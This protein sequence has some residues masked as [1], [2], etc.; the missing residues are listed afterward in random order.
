MIDYTFFK[1]E[2]II[3]KRLMPGSSI[4]INQIDLDPNFFVWAT[5]QDLRKFNGNSWEYYD[6]TNSS[7]P[8]G[9][10][11][12]LDTRC[13]SID[14]KGILWGGIA[15]ASNGIN[16]TNS[17]DVDFYN[18][19]SSGFN[20]V[21]YSTG[22]QSDGKIIMG[23]GFTLFNGF[24][25]N[26]LLRLNPDG[27]ED[28]SFYSNLGTGFNGLILFDSIKIQSDGKILVGGTFNIFNGNTRNGL[29]RLNSDGTEDTSFYTNLG[30]GF[31]GFIYSI[32]LQADGKILVGG[33]FNSFNGN[34]RN[35]IVRL[36]PD[37][38]EDTSFYT[39]V[40]STGTGNAFN[41]VVYFIREQIDGRILV[42][43]NYLSFNGGTRRRLVRLNPSGL[44]DSS[45]YTNLSPLGS[46]FNAAVYGIAIQN[47]GKIIITG[48][49]NVLDSSLRDKIVRLNSNGSEDTQFYTNVTSTGDGSGFQNGG[50]SR[51]SIQTDGKIIV[52]GSFTDFNDNGGFN[53]NR[54]LRLNPD[55]TEDSSFYTPISPGFDIPGDIY[56]SEIQP[57]GKILLG[58]DFTTFAGNTRNF[59]IRLNSSTETPSTPLVFK[60]DTSEVTVGETWYS[61]D[62]S[63]F[64]N[65][66]YETSLIYSSPYGNEVLAY[67][68]PLNGTGSVG[69]TAYTQINGVTG[70]RLFFYD[71]NIEKWNE[72]ISGYT[73]PHIFSIK[74]KGYKGKEYKYFLGT[75]E[76]LWVI[77]PGLLT[78][79]SLNEGGEIVSQARVYNTSTSGIIS[80]QVYTLDFD[81]NGN[82]W[83]GTDQGIS[84]FDGHKFWNYDTS[85]PV[86]YIKSRENGHVFYSIGD[87]ELSQGTGLWHFNGTTHTNINSSN[88]NLPNDN[89]INIDLIENGTKQSNLT[90]YENSLWI[91]CLNEISSF[92]YD[93]PHVYA[94]SKS[95]GATGWNFTYRVPYGGTGATGAPPLAK[96]NK[97]TWGYPEWQTY[98]TEFVSSKL[99]GTDPRNLFLTV[100]LKD[101]SDGK[102]GE[103][104]YWSNSPIANHEEKVLSEKIGLS[105]WESPV[106]VGG[107]GGDVKITCSTSIETDLGIKYFVG[108][109]ITGETQAFFGYY[110]DSSLAYVNNLNPTIG[111]SG[112]TAGSSSYYGE[113]GFVVCYDY[114]GSVESILPFRGYKTRV[115]SLDPSPD[116]NSIS[117]SGSYS[118]FIESGPW[119]WN[120]W[121]GANSFSGNGAT[122]SPYGATNLNYPGLT[123]GSYPWIYD[124]LSSFSVLFSSFWTYDPMATST[125]SSG[126]FDFS[127][128]GSGYNI[129]NINGIYISFIDDTSIDYTSQMESL[130]TANSIEVSLFPSIYTITSISSIPSGLFIGLIYQ[131]GSTG[132]IPFVGGTSLRLDFYEWNNEAYPLVKNIG[133]FPGTPEANSYGVFSA[134]IHRE[135]GNKFSF[136]GITGDYNSGINSS[137]RVKKFR[138]FPVKNLNTLPGNNYVPLTSI[139][140]T[141]YHTHLL[142][143][144]NLSGNLADLSTLKNDWI[145]TNDN[146]SVDNYLSDPAY[147][148]LL[149]YV[150][151]NNLDYSLQSNYNSNTPGSTGGWIRVGSEINALDLGESVVI[152]GSATGGFYFSGN[153]LSPSGSSNSPF[154]ISIT[155]NP[156]GS[157]GFYLESFGLTGNKIDVT[158][159]KS[160]YYIT[161]VVGS[162]GSYFGKNFVAEPDK[163]YFLTSKLT[164]QTVCKSIFYPSVTG[165][166]PSLDL[167]NTLKLPNGQF[168]VHYED[169]DDLYTVKVLKTDE[170]SRINDMIT[171]SGFN[172]DLSLSTDSD[173]NILFSGFNSLGLTGSAYVNFGYVNVGYIVNE[174][175]E[176][177]IDFDYIDVGYFVNSASGFVYLLKQYKPNLGINEGEIISRPGSDPWVWSDSHVKEEGSFEVPLMST[178]IFNNYSSEIYGKNNNKWILSNSATGEEILNIK[179][180]PYFIY[181]FTEEGEYTI[182]N[183]VS[184][185]EGNVYATTGNGFIKVIDHK[186]MRIPGVKSGPINSINYGAE[187]PFDIKSYQGNKVARDIEKEQKEIEKNN[188]S[189]FAPAVTIEDNPDIA[190]KKVNIK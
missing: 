57:D 87:G 66:L 14:N 153:Y 85:G 10:P 146:S 170:D 131:S 29:V 145:W 151:I 71:E 65:L 5:G 45:F 82:L 122:G 98:D 163:T 40:T 132:V 59:S 97:Y 74:A 39:S 76:G 188:K 116:D 51:A 84:F 155:D 164:E 110:N 64:D 9:S 162:S 113:M 183:E 78:T 63:T 80:N 118:W 50:T 102:A 23:G 150:K 105:M 73:W 12:Y 56:S 8:S 2:Y 109:Y 128:D 43:G 157:T 144:S 103:Q 169:Y 36:N 37:G 38:T 138:N 179:Y 175:P 159:D 19:R 34:T 96:M 168:V 7:V 48:D 68:T 77:P 172:G 92:T 35:R 17:E 185:S 33:S 101:I 83:I 134:E 32:C 167:K 55:G 120:S 125:I 190:Y 143:Q 44:E 154:Y 41:S 177:F 69:A 182:F 123:S 184:D 49:F 6:S 181:T 141:N 94:S 47:D 16:P 115:D 93:L 186:K 156:V 13:I 58:G 176:T 148:G 88:S 91:L 180:S 149:S 21:V 27:T 130:V 70:G 108:G 174:I 46:G 133:S 158:K 31:I 25:R 147:T 139:Q 20:D 112:G 171:V 173:S 106:G 140:R 30:T 135:I 81:E 79:L 89:I 15:Q 67:I 104:Y 28:T 3:K 26:R 121:E 52:G 111:G 86:T 4:Y 95:E 53:R 178:V 75:T 18:Q 11:Y 100:P 160:H 124:P 90:L 107:S 161:T 166:N 54:I 129:E 60:L 22:V 1:K 119:V 99:P 189:R 136:T 61:Y 137:Y 24:T 114:S 187:G 42:S 117:V 127:Y 165:S 142:I 72:T 152:T 62:I 126:E